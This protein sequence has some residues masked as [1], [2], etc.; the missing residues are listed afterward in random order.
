[1]CSR[2]AS[3]AMYRTTTTRRKC[4]LRGLPVPWTVLAK[5]TVLKFRSL[6]R[7]SAMAAAGVT[8]LCALTVHATGDPAG[9]RAAPRPGRS[10]RRPARLQAR[11]HGIA[12]R[13][14]PRVSA[15]DR[16]TRRLPAQDLPRLLPSPGPRFD[17]GRQACPRVARGVRRVPY[18]RTVLPPV[19]ECAGPTWSVERLPRQLRPSESAAAR[20]NYVRALYR[21]GEREAALKQVRDL[22]VAPE[23]QPKTCDP[24]FDVW[25]AGGH[26]DQDAVWERLALALDAN[27]VSLGRYLLRFFN[28]TN[29]AA[30]R[31]YYDAHVR[32]RTV[33]SMGRFPDTDGGRRALRHGLLRYA[34]DQPRRTRPVA[35]GRGR[36]RILDGRQALYPGVADGCQRGRRRGAGGRPGRLLDGGGGTHRTRPDPSPALGSRGALGRRL[37]AALHA[38]PQWRYWHG[39]ALDATGNPAGREHLTAAPQAATTTASWRRTASARRRPSTRCRRATT[40]ARN[41]PFSR[42]R[43]FGEWWSCTRSATWST[44]A[45]NGAMPHAPS[46]AQSNVSSSN[47]PVGSAG[48]SRRSS[49]PVM[50]SCWTWCGSGSDAVLEHLPPPRHECEFACHLPARCLAPGKRFQPE[51]CLGGRGPRFD[52]VDAVHR[53]ADRQPA[54]RRAHQ[55]TATS[56]TPMP[57]STSPRIISP[58]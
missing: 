47:S 57:T 58:P 20:C 7:P 44:P 35:Q 50:P 27:E 8:L 23:S 40:Q 43:R 53:T 28:T 51:G 29:A 45:A 37:P 4:D 12:R 6:P 1:M 14:Q 48:S 15:H 3:A 25:I 31:L 38:T 16:E 18:R 41:E 54:P 5:P 49:V 46:M 21:S 30:G 11:H 10:L 26:L 32:P 55:A 33:R 24:L 9:T 36:L 22:W 34:E 17:H 19:A 42:C 39:R 52:A 13:T 2:F 56:S